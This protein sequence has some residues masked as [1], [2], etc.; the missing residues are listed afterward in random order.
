MDTIIVVCPIH[1]KKYYLDSDGYW[2]SNREDA[3][4]FWESQFPAV[5]NDL[6]GNPHNHLQYCHYEIV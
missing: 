1:D 4:C 2:T 6:A 3:Q 5:L